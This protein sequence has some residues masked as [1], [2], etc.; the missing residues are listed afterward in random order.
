MIRNVT[1]SAEE[2][3]ISEARSKARL[4][5]KSMNKLFREWLS[6]YVGSERKASTYEKL[7]DRLDHVNSG[8]VFSREELNER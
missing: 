7:M 5:R 2:D 8:R 6:T 3:L 1:L 4:E